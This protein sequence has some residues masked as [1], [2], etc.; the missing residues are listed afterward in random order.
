M[1]IYVKMISLLCLASMFNMFHSADSH[2]MVPVFEHH[3]VFLVGNDYTSGKSYLYELTLIDGLR[4]IGDTGVNN[5]RGIDF[6]SEGKLM[7]LCET[8]DQNSTPVTVQLDIQYG[9]FEWAAEG[10]ISD[11]V[12]DITIG[13]DGVLY[14]LEVKAEEKLNKHPKE[15]DFFAMLVG[16]PDIGAEYHA[17]GDGGVEDCIKTAAFVGGNPKFF[18]ID[19][20]TGAT[21]FIA[22]LEFTELSSVESLEFAAMDKLNFPANDNID[23]AVSAELHPAEF[24][25]TE[26][27]FIVLLNYKEVKEESGGMVTTNNAEFSESL[28]ALLDTDTYTL[29]HH[30]YNES[31]EPIIFQAIAVMERGPRPIPTLSEWG[32][33]AMAGIL[34]IVG[35]M[36]IRRRKVS[37]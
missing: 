4:M 20:E 5:C 23:V 14:S 21:Q 12:S 35:F 22:D 18:K 27:E 28:I 26:A 32:L 8:R 19:P 17:L 25:E 1:K 24:T 6:N 34:G 9:G 7:A 36:V 16:Y 33:I 11:R 37:A 13:D 3:R 15:N 30:K 31:Q 2:A 10:G 29:A